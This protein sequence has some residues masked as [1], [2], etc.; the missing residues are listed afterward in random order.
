MVSS[1]RILEILKKSISLDYLKQVTKNKL[2]AFVLCLLNAGRIGIWKYWILRKGHN[3]EYL[4]KNLSEHSREPKTNSRQPTYGA[5]LEMDP[6]QNW[7][8]ASALTTARSR[9]PASV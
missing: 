2:F 8:E 1:N 9:Y 3:P 6:G 7:W 5:K 4:E